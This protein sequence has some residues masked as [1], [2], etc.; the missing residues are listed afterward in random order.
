MTRLMG[1]LMKDLSTNGQFLYPP[2]PDHP[3]RRFSWTLDHQSSA[4]QALVRVS[5]VINQ[6]LPSALIKPQ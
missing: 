1:K 6:D 4:V 3:Y 5:I 2:N